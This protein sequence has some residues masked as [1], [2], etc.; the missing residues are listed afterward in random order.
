[1]A[2]SED[3]RDPL[4]LWR[5]VRFFFVVTII[6]YLIITGDA[7]ITL[8]ILAHL[9]SVDISQ[10]RIIDGIIVYG[11]Q[12]L[13]AL[14]VLCALASLR[15]I[16][17]LMK[18]AHERP[19]GEELTSPVMAVGYF[20]IPFVSLVMPPVVMGQIWRNAYAA[21][22]NPRQ[23]SALIG[24]WWFCYLGGGILLLAGSFMLKGD[25]ITVAAYA[26]TIAGYVVRTLA[27]VLFVM[28]LG[29]LSHA[30]AEFSTAAEAFS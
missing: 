28:L 26:I 3:W 8:S 16:Y 11:S 5:W 1:M 6:G 29:K 18:N 7:L 13:V 21:R 12:V 10:A 25:G 9:I 20:F 23:G 2:L 4:S 17:R 30:Q 24:W 27:A 19:E 15:L 14:F 22:E